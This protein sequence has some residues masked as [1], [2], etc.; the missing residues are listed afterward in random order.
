MINQIN[1]FDF[2]SNSRQFLFILVVFCASIII[3]IFIW[4]V[5]PQITLKRRKKKSVIITITGNKKKRLPSSKRWFFFWNTCTP[6]PPPPLC[7][8]KKTF[9]F[10]HHHHHCSRRRRRYFFFYVA[11]HMDIFFHSNVN[12]STTVCVCLVM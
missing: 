2:D 12:K 1:R 6:S 8:R 3:Y 5:Q 9:R 10:R 4:F 7:S 11:I